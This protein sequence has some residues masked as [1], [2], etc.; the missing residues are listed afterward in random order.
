MSLLNQ[1]RG[2]SIHVVQV[3]AVPSAP[4]SQANEFTFVGD[5]GG[6]GHAALL[7]GTY[8][9]TWNADADIASDC[10]FANVAVSVK[11]E[12]SATIGAKRVV[13]LTVDG[14]TGTEM[15]T[16]VPTSARWWHTRTAHVGGRG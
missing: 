12:G 8:R 9:F 2:R 14:Y 6:V 11:A 1:N 5:S 16:N 15:L 7:P 13:S 3:R 10:D 4:L